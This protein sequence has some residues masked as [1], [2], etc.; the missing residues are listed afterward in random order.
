MAHA[1][2]VFYVGRGQFDDS[3][4]SDE[5]FIRTY[6]WIEAG[7]LSFSAAKNRYQFLLFHDIEVPPTHIKVDAYLGDLPWTEAQ[8]IYV[9]AHHGEVVEG[10]KVELFD[11]P[12]TEA[13]MKTVYFTEADWRPTPSQPATTT[14]SAKTASTFWSAR[15]P[16][17]RPHPRRPPSP[18]RLRSR[19]HHRIQSGSRV[20]KPR[21]QTRRR[22]S[23]PRRITRQRL[24]T[25][26]ARAFNL[27]RRQPH[28]PCDEHA[29]DL[30]R[31]LAD[32]QDLRISPESSD[33]VLVHETVSAMDLGG[34]TGV[35]H[36][37]LRGVE[38]R[39]RGLLL[40]GLAPRHSRPPGTRRAGPC[41][42]ASP[43]LR[44]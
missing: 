15:V 12:G 33:G 2:A 28:I 32:L 35:R 10:P 20:G 13:A 40:E 16:R 42:S 3:R 6:G 38:L 41:R 14:P 8:D 39:D 31:A 30:R 7:W 4:P 21:R 9:R 1:H 11:M 17:P 43:Y 26:S 44:S 36:R 34:L 27:K 29:L 37:D 23:C 22:P 19:H 25:A 24:R 18:G 5:W